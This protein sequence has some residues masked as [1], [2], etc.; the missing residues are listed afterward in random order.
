[1][2]FMK[3]VSCKVNYLLVTNN[4]SKFFIISHIIYPQVTGYQCMYLKKV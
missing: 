4:I 1:M 3:K 2:Y